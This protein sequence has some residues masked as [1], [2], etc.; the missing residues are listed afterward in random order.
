MREPSEK[1]LR[2]AAE[3]LRPRGWIVVE[4]PPTDNLFGCSY[5]NGKKITC[6]PLVD[7]FALGVLF[8]E[9][10]H[11]YLQHHAETCA[12]EF[13]QEY[14]AEI[15]AIAALRSKGFYVPKKFIEEARQNVGRA[16]ERYKG[17]YPP[18]EKIL[19]FAYGAHWRDY[20]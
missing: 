1:R 15:W 16:I 12:P 14:E 19:K 10:G 8:H 3:S 17:D 7:R 9:Y 2:E 20:Q 11:V 6:P 4:R 18:D 13:F 5:W